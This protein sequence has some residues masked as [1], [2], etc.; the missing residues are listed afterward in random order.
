MPFITDDRVFF[1]EHFKTNLLGT[2]SPHLLLMSKSG[3]INF[4]HVHFSTLYFGSTGI[5][6]AIVYYRKVCEDVLKPSQEGLY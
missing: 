4:M 6:E 5:P 2:S 1:V 3:K